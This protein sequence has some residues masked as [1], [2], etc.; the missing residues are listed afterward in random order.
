[1]R[2]VWYFLLMYDFCFIG[3]VW[4]GGVMA[5][6]FVYWSY[7]VLRRG[8]RFCLFGIGLGC[9]GCHGRVCDGSLVVWQ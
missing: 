4:F 1:M 7:R 6:C 5:G 9:F 8:V 3:V 2:V